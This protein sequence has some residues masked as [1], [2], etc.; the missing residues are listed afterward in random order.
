MN[1]SRNSF[2]YRVCEDRSFSP[3]SYGNC[4][5]KVKLRCCTLFVHDWPIRKTHQLSWLQL[6]LRKWWSK[7]CSL[8][9]VLPLSIQ[10]SF[11]RTTSRISISNYNFQK[12]RTT[13]SF[14]GLDWSAFSEWINWTTVG[15]SV[16]VE[17]KITMKYNIDLFQKIWYFLFLHGL[18]QYPRKLWRGWRLWNHDDKFVLSIELNVTKHLNY[19]YSFSK[20]FMFSFYCGILKYIM[21]LLKLLIVTQLLII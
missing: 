16:Y 14:A 11:F 10:N 2:Q 18:F 17:E 8:F 15:R 4:W 1:S 12:K 21:L 7:D 3:K 5:T 13:I 19:H 6:C 20:M 9:W